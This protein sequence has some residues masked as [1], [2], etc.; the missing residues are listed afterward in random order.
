MVGRERV[1]DRAIDSRQDVADDPVRRQW[2]IFVR[3][4]RRAKRRKAGEQSRFAATI[5]RAK[6]GEM[7]VNAALGVRQRGPAHLVV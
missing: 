5:E 6:Y 1:H 7:C 2:P 4:L 3:D